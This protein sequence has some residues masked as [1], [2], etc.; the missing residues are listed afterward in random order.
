M[1]YEVIYP[2]GGR[3]ANI[4]ALPQLPP[5]VMLQIAGRISVG[6]RHYVS[7]ELLYNLMLYYDFRLKAHEG[8]LS[9]SIQ[10]AA[11]DVDQAVAVRDALNNVTYNAYGGDLRIIS[12]REE[13]LL[14]CISYMRQLQQGTREEAAIQQQ[15]SWD[16]SALHSLCINYSGDWLDVQNNPRVTERTDVT[17]RLPLPIPPFIDSLGMT[18]EEAISVQDLLGRTW[19]YSFRVIMQMQGSLQP[20]L[21]SLMQD[22]Y[23]KFLTLNNFAV[24]VMRTALTNRRNFDQDRPG[25]RRETVPWVRPWNAT[26]PS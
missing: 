8:H 17:S 25:F 22:T 1:L 26:G 11:N 2:S 3:P 13:F 20:E 24:A 5:E 19:Y 6:V 14:G 18:F 21:G 16:F 23:F 4:T 15:Y 12:L 7:P 10:R 9:V